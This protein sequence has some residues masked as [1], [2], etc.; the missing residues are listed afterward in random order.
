[1]PKALVIDAEKCVGC[2]TCELVCSGKHEGEVNPRLSR[3]KVI[4]GEKE[5]GGFPMVCFQCEQ[6]WCIAACPS[7][8]ITRDEALGR[9]VIDY[10]KCIGCRLCAMFC[11]F[12]NINFDVIKKRVIK[13]DLCDGDPQCAKFCFYGAVQY[14]DVRDIGLAKQKEKVKKLTAL[15]RDMP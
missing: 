12:G 13:C 4:R 6:A 1:M 10:D 15:V 7:K 3:M 9:V 2:K 11:P 8:A 5:W 14:V